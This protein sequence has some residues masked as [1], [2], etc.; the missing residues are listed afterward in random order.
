[1]MFP[2]QRLGG[3]GE[4]S[5]QIERNKPDGKAKLCR[6]VLQGLDFTKVIG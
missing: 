5:A 1:M 3:F 4:P 6:L 2:L